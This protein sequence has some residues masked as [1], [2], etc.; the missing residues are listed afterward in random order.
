MLADVIYRLI[1][2]P[3]EYL[4]EVLFLVLQS[5]FGHNLVITLLGLSVSVTVLTLPLYSR[6]EKKRV[7]GLAVKESVKK[8]RN[9]IHDSFSGDE[10]IMMKGYLN[11]VFHQGI[12]S[13]LTAALPLLIQ[14]PF[15]TAAYNF[16]S[17][18]PVLAENSFFGLFMLDKPD[19]MLSIGTVTLNVLP[20]LMTII[21]VISTII[22]LE[23]R[24]LKDGIQSFILAAVFLV[25]LYDSPSGLTLYWL[26]NNFI[27]LLKNVF[28][29]FMKSRILIKEKRSCKG[30]Y[31]FKDILALNIDL[32]L[33]FGALIPVLT[34]SASPG[35]FVDVFDFVSPLHYVY[36]TAACYFGFFVIWGSFFYSLFRN[37]GY[38]NAVVSLLVISLF[39]TLFFG[40]GHGYISNVLVYDEAPFYNDTDITIGIIVVLTVCIVAAYAHKERKSVGRIIGYALLPAMVICIL[41]GLVKIERGVKDVIKEGYADPD[42]QEDRLITLSRNEKNVVVIG[43]DRA[44]GALLP[45]LIK[46]KPQ[47]KEMYDGFVWY[48]DTLSMGLVTRIG[49]PPLYG[50][51]EYCF[52]NILKRTDKSRG[53][54]IDEEMRLLPALFSKQGFNVT[55]CNDPLWQHATPWNELFSD[56]PNVKARVIDGKYVGHATFI[57]IDVERRYIFYSI[58]RTITPLFASDIYDNGYYNQIAK[59]SMVNRGFWKTYS[60]L[61]KLPELIDVKDDAQGAFLLL[62]NTSTHEPCILQQPD[63]VPAAE[64]DNSEY[65]DPDRFELEGQRLNVTKSLESHYH[66]N[67]AALLRIGEWLEYL[68]QEGVYDNTRIIIAADHGAPINVYGIDPIGIPGIEGVNPLLLVKDFDAHGFNVSDDFMTNADVPCLAVEGII[69][70]PVN[71]FTGNPLTM[72]PKK[73][74]LAVAGGIL[75]KD[76]LDLLKKMGYDVDQ[77]RTPVVT[78]HDSIFDMDNWEFYGMMEW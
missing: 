46:E 66:V 78:V 68:K 33:L 70:D 67:M 15:F 28:F 51:Y 75:E 1:V 59:K 29:R 57:D 5:F 77:S 55:V 50:G 9:H 2:L 25:L 10:R 39:N 61:L 43:L 72:E 58:F 13:E 40:R 3:L 16:I 22:Y 69:Q 34:I 44:I 74:K 49:Q 24:P 64:V 23:K 36:T 30:L 41:Y 63:Y 12:R 31:T 35:D 8:W 14:I 11:R 48:P 56:L 4:Y 54:I 53:Q 20:I 71:P 37:D 18:L 19:G 47:L 7:E 26:S 65:I 52:D 76:E 62:Y 60:S 42:A 73:N 21:N 45:Y 32:A 38:V 17:G 27:S 6:A